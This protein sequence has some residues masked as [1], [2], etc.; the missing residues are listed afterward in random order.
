[1][2]D[3]RCLYGLVD[4]VRQNYGVL[5]RSQPQ[6][7]SGK[8]VESF[9]GVVEVFEQLKDVVLAEDIFHSTDCVL[10]WKS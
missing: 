6:E 3:M 8:L 2:W 1:M 4:K 9:C 7:P 5:G 10:W